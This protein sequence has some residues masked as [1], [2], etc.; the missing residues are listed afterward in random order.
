MDF[1][2][3]AANFHVPVS[4]KAAQEVASK[5]MPEQNLLDIKDFKAHYKPMREYLQGLNIATRQKPGPPVKV[6]KSKADA[7]E[8]YRKGEIDVD[9]PIRIVDKS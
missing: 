4:R 7:K 9:D 8:A 6:F 5:M 2:G 1:D 3:D